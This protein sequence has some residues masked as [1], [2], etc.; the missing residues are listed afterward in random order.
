MALNITGEK[1]RNKKMED[2]KKIAGINFS[3][4]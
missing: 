3:V 4:L 1:S 2:R